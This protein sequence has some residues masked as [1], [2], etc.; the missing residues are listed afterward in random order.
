MD[1]Q[2]AAF[3]A[4]GADYAELASRLWD[5]LGQILAGYAAPRRGERVLDACCGTGA[6]ALPAARA[7]G[8]T[9]RV[10]AVD[11]A[12][13][14]LAHGRVAATGLPQLRF[15]HGD[16]SR[17]RP[18]DGPY[19]LVQSGYG[20]FF[21]PDM[22]AGG[23]H[24]VSLLRPGGRF[25]VQTWRQGALASF[26]ACL[27]DTVAAE[28]PA[29]LPRWQPPSASGRIDTSAKLSGWL[30]SLGL[31]DGRVWNVDYV[32]PLTPGLAW[33]MVSGSGWRLLLAGL[34]DSTRARIR[35][36]LLR[37][38]RQRG[39]TTLDAGSLAGTAYAP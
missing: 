14:L 39:L 20:V 11:L 17:W 1:Q 5:E 35:G 23:S 38:I 30:S 28:A 29:Q 12:P 22:D 34:G 27:F 26:A 9:G 7:V 24:L 32:Q 13:S 8:P 36:G 18:A 21:L 4:A 19:D 15:I 6:S 33:N 25:A 31:V 2:A 16:V 37:R 3:D 10:D